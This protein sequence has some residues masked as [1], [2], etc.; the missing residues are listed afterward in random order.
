MNFRILTA[1]AALVCAA[2]I[3]GCA[4]NVNPV[5][6][7]RIYTPVSSSTEAYYGRKASEEMIKSYGVYKEDAALTAYVDRVG[8]ALAMGVV[9]K[10]VKYTFTILN[11]D[12]INAFALPGGYVF[13][14]RGALNFA[15]SEAELAGLLGHEIGHVDAFHFGPRK[16]DTVKALLSVLL[17]NSAKTAED[18]AL[19]KKLADESTQSSGYSQDQEFEADALSI[20]YMALAGYDPKAMVSAMRTED[21]KEK[22]DDGQMKGNPVAHDIFALDQSHPTTPDR[23]ARAEEA[24]KNAVTVATTRAIP[25]SAAIPASG[26]VPAPGVNPKIA[27]DTYLAAIDGM[28]FGADPSEGK[29]EGRRFINPALNF[30]FEAPEG[31]ELWSGRGGGFGISSTAVMLFEMGEG[32]PGATIESQL[33]S[34]L[35]GDMHAD[36]I[37]QLIIKGY[38]AATGFIWLEPFIVRVGVI[39]FNGDHLCRMAYI[40]PRRVFYHLDSAFLDSFSTVR[41]L[42]GADAEPIPALH[43]HIVTVASGDT[44]ESLAAGMAVKEKK[45]EWFRVLNGLGATDG[46][47]AG[48]RVKVVVE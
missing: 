28:T 48:E 17:R 34:N 10:S 35:S 19:A 40:S 44:V 32:Q 6:G 15:N 37:H 31:F 9:R 13:I 21:A 33:T 14:T 47:Q 11:E 3:S 27:H 46:V 29:T 42:D 45:V 7:K 4:T 16:H 24:A 26:V 23:M 20:H 43:I 18:Q 36:K 12:E 25:D 38:Q 39:R 2:A 1:I 30:S 41:T 5:T 22:L 8:Q